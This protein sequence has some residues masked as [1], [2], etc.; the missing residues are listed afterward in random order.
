MNDICKKN[1]LSDFDFI[2]KKAL[3]D[4]EADEYLKY[5]D[6]GNTY[7]EPKL[8]LPCYNWG[9]IVRF[10]DYKYYLPFKNIYGRFYY[11]AI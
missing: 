9:F 11:F 7:S 10:L 2:G 6:L 4:I 8:N 1:P 5:S 3:R